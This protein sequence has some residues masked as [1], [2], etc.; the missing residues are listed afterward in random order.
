MPTEHARRSARAEAVASQ[1]SNLELRA[2]FGQ[3]LRLLSTREGSVS[4]ACRALGINRTQFNRYLTGTAFPRPDLLYRICRHYGVDARIL[5]E[6]LNDTAPPKMSA[7]LARVLH[8]VIDAPLDFRLDQTLLPSGIYRLWR[9]SFL[10]PDR[11]IMSLARVWRDG[12]VTRMKSYEPHLIS[13]S[14]TE[15]TRPAM[16]PCHGIFL[17]AEDG[18]TL[19]TLFPATR[20]LRFSYFRQGLAGFGAL[21]PGYSVLGRDHA[22]GMV[23]SGGTVL[24]F[25]PPPVTGLMALARSAGYRDAATVPAMFRNHLLNDHP[26]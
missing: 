7:E 2:V 21:Y 13:P 3:N 24:E 17:R 9:R 10:L 18:I 20:M 11:V 8:E 15:I 14:Q 25:L 16:H 12:L 5:L 1:P 22:D 23:R 4:A 26:L 6:P 19:V